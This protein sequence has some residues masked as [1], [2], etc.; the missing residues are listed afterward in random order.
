M[1]RP[2]TYLDD[3]AGAAFSP[4]GQP[5]L[6]F[7]A[8]LN[9][10][11]GLDEI[12][13]FLLGPNS[14]DTHDV[15]WLESDRGDGASALAW[16][17]RG[18]LCASELYESLLT[19]YWQREKEENELENPNFTEVLETGGALLSAKKIQGLAL[20]IWPLP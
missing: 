14:A 10:G 11:P 2:L 12:L 7:K 18:K 5:Q 16:L 3:P 20:Q 15:L 4:L 1:T 9:H 17:P 6:L 19:A 8:W 13:L